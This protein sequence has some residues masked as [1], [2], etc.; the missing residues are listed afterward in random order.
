[1]SSIGARRG[2]VLYC[3][4]LYSHKATKVHL[5]LIPLFA[6]GIATK[7]TGSPL[8]YH[9]KLIFH[10]IVCPFCCSSLITINVYV[11]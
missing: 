9:K 5:T 11:T 3:I 8:V 1:M 4:G 10:L 2:G 6:P 7:C